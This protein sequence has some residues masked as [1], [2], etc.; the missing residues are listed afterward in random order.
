MLFIMLDDQFEKQY[1]DTHTETHTHIPKAP[2]ILKPSAIGRRVEPATLLN[3]QLAIYFLGTTFGAHVTCYESYSTGASEHTSI[4]L[5]VLFL[6]LFYLIFFFWFL[7]LTCGWVWLCVFLCVWVRVHLLF[8]S[9]KLP[10][11]WPPCHNMAVHHIETFCIPHSSLHNRILIEGP[12]WMFDNTQ[13]TN[14]SSV[15]DWVGWC[16]PF[17]GFLIKLF[18]YKFSLLFWFAGCR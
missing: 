2:K 11:G 7:G 13:L 1:A 10:C 9:F 14:W 3:L 4:F 8:I 18:A 6:F 16:F 17:C 5:S 15:D 12:F